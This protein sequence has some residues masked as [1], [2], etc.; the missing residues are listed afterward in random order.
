[1]NLKLEELKPVRVGLG[2]GGVGVGR[3][4]LSAA[5]ERQFLLMRASAAAGAAEHI[6]FCIKMRSEL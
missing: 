5:L 6:L 3:L 4:Q 2:W 1:M